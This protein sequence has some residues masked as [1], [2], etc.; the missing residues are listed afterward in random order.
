V[1]PV[2]CPNTLL[3]VSGSRYLRF[4]FLA[5]WL[6]AAEMSPTQEER[7]ARATPRQGPP[8]SARSA[9]QSRRRV[10]LFD[11]EVVIARDIELDEVGADRVALVPRDV[12]NGRE[13]FCKAIDVALA[14][15]DFRLVT[16]AGCEEAVARSNNLETRWHEALAHQRGL[17]CERGQAVRDSAAC[18][19]HS[20]W[21]P[22]TT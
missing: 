11:A 15:S 10:A 19:R 6:P 18:L 14:R 1:S 16:V 13:P 7:P 20:R 8:A 2:R 9:P 21:A 22:T 17:I 5:L 12:F 4:Q 3:G